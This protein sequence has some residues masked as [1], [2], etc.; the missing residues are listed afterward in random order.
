MEPQIYVTNV[1]IDYIKRRIAFNKNFLAAIV[2]DTGSGK[3]Y[4]ALF[5]A[6]KT[7]ST[8]NLNNV[9]LN[10]K[11]FIYLIDSGRLH[12]GSAVVVDEAGVSLQ[13]RDSM[14]NKNKRLSAILQTFRNRNYICFFTLPDLSFM[15]KQ[16]RKLLHMIFETKKINYQA[17]YC[18]LTCKFTGIDRISGKAYPNFPIFPVGGIPTRISRI[19]IPLPTQ[20]LRD[21]YEQKKIDHL[22][23]EY[24]EYK[25]IIEN[26][27]KDKEALLAALKKIVKM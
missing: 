23:A 11:E 8:F 4:A 18:T 25:E 2:G 9:V 21:A 1:I 27:D 6:E 20:E 7:D 14:T 26:Q 22:N 10:G 13:T 12:K 16:A 17:G 5:L 3:S 15:D 19:T 24:K